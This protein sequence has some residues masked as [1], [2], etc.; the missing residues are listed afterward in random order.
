MRTA[1]IIYN[2]AAGRFPVALAIPSAEHAL[3]DAGW[4]VS[5]TSTR[6][7]EDGTYLAKKAVEKGVNAVFAVG[8]DG[9]IGQIASGLVDTETALGILPAGTANVWGKE[10]GMQPYSFLANNALEENAKKLANASIYAVDVGVCNQ[11]PFLMWAGLGLD[12]LSV[13]KAEPRFRLEKFFTMP[14]YA[15]S[16]LLTAARWRGI[17]LKIWADGEEIE[18]HYILAVINNI[19][20]YMGG[21]TNLSPDA[22]LDD[23]IFDL[24]LF[25]GNNMADALRPVVEMWGGRHIDSAHTHR[26]PFKELRLEADTDFAIQTD[27]EPRFDTKSATISVKKRALRVLMP[28]NGLSA[29]SQEPLS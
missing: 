16:I 28:P 8:G 18:G 6:S 22:M 2:P 20:H 1:Q 11:Q 9:T 25:S 14:E 23:G 21:M 3:R 10:L 19:R 24:W 12:A 17:S 29:L 15:T 7:G 4:E 5:S 13:Q 27:G 26:V